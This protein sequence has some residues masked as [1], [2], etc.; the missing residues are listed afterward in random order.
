VLNPLEITPTEAQVIILGYEPRIWDRRY[1]ALL[2][3]TRWLPASGPEGAGPEGAATR[4]PDYHELELSVELPAGW[5]AAGPGRRHVDESESGAD[6]VRYRWSPPSP[7]P[8]AALIAG[9]LES[10]ATEVKGVQVE[11]LIDESHIGNVDFFEDAAVE[12]GE[13]L[14][15]HLDE[16]S[17]L[18]LDY[19][20]DGLTLVEIPMALR[21][22]G[23]G[24]RMDT[25]MVQPAMIM[26]RE[27]SFPTARFDRAFR[28]PDAFRDREGG[29]PR[30]KREMLERFFENDMNGGNPFVGAARSFFGFQTAATG[31]GG[32]PLDYVCETLATRLLTDKQSYF[33]IHLFDSQVGQ[34]FQ[35]AGFQMGSPDRIGNSF[36]EVMIHMLTS[37]PRVW[38]LILEVS[39]TDLDPWEDPKKTI[40]VLSLKGGAMSQSLLDGLGREKSGTLLATLREENTGAHFSQADVVEAGAQIEEDLERWLEVWLNST[41]LPGF[42]VGEI[43]AERITDSEDG[44]PRYQVLATIHNGEPTPGLIRVNYRAG[45][46]QSGMERDSL[47]PV[48][49]EASTAMQIGVVTSKPPRMVR[50]HPYLALN[51][52]PF[53]LTLPPID[54]ERIVEAE[55][56][57]GARVV[58]WE[59]VEEDAIVVDD[60][61]PGF[62]VEGS[63]KGSWLRFARGGDEIETDAGLPVAET[64]WRPPA[65][66]SRRST[67][68]AYGKYR[69]TLALA[70]AGSGERKAIFSAEIPRAGEWELE[71]HVPRLRRP[72]RRGGGGMTGTWKLAVV[73][74]SGSRDVDLDL[75]AAEIGWN[76]MGSFELAGGVVRVEV[77]NETDGRLVVADAIRW[78]PVAVGD[79]AEAR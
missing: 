67:A 14:T 34:T 5:L 15:E 76:S 66:W 20:Y 24:W 78:V 58:D 17:E 75:A 48:L 69:H 53:A 25:T 52:D 31:P 18:G 71:Y 79:I 72:G 35:K 64:P 63:G 39:L 59:P 55:P 26:M 28:D 54:E 40:D 38:D 77:S 1:V 4:P 13:W 62:S 68:T 7:V 12:I 65:S 30:A 57:T 8:D 22:F 70:K 41:D 45:D 74:D 6:R 44:A 3:G 51:R 36:A 11:V 2:P 23:G 61:D 33:S 73:D 29:G 32:M 47:E 56:F 9:R 10:R 37:T 19:P 43:T 46:R 42:T 27:S 49:V 50:I 16:A 21:G 60:L